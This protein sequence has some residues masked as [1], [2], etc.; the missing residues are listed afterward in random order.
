MLGVEGKHAPGDLIF[1]M[2][3][4]K[5]MRPFYLSHFAKKMVLSI[6]RDGLYGKFSLST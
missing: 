3:I 6:V 1:S 2:R 4:K 5:P